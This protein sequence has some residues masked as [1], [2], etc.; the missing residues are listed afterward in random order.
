MLLSSRLEQ[1]QNGRLQTSTIIQTTP[2]PANPNATIKYTSGP[3]TKKQIMMHA[4]IAKAPKTM[5]QGGDD[6]RAS[7]KALLFLMEALYTIREGVG[8]RNDLSFL[9]I[10]FFVK[11]V[12]FLV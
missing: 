4:S 5:S 9:P 7:L 11:L 1:R 10:T 12:V 3:F 2:F 8:R 6:E